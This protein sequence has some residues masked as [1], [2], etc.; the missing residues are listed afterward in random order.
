[1]REN[2]LRA[3]HFGHAGRDAMLREAT[4]VWWQRIHREIV[5]KARKFVECQKA[6]KNLNCVNCEKEF[7]KIPEAKDRKDEISP[8]FAGP[9]QNAYKQKKYLL[10]SI[11]NNSGCPAAMFLPSPSADKVV[12]FLLDYIA[13]NGIPKRIRTDPGTVFTGAKNQQFCKE[14][15]IQHT[16]CPIRDHRGNGK[17]ER[18]IRTLNE[19]LRTNRKRLVQK[20]RYIGTV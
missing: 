17:V 3:I 1:M 18:M 20:E 19:R 11:D 6:G 15:F 14:R 2:V 7:G 9:F 5:E 13:M 8:G 10:V 16:M 12:E 4:D